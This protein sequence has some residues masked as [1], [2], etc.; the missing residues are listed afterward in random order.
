MN[1][2]FYFGHMTGKHI[3]ITNLER[4]NPGIGGTE[5]QFMLLAYFLSKEK[6]DWQIYCLI[7]ND[8]FTCEELNIVN[9]GNNNLLPVINNLKIDILILPKTRFQDL[10]KI[11][12]PQHLKLIT[13]C[14]N[15]LDSINLRL[16][17]KHKQIKANVFVGKQFYDLYSDCNII[18]KTMYIYNIIT[19]PCEQNIERQINSKI[20]VYIGAL[21]KAKG[22][23]ELAKIWKDILK[24]VPDAKLYVIGN[25][26]LYD[27]DNELGPLG[28]ADKDFEEEFLPY[29][30]NENG[31]LPNVKF[32]G[33]LGD[34]KYDIFSK[35]SVGVANPSGRTETFC[36]TVPE[37]NCATLPV[38][39][40]NKYSFPDVII[41]GQTG[42]LGKNNNEIKK[43]I[44]KLL[45]N[46]ELNKRLGLNA[47][48][49]IEKF[50]P[51]KM[52]VQWIELLEK[53]QN[54]TFAPIYCPPSPPFNNCYKWV[55]I[56]NRFLRFNCKLS[57]L[58]P[59]ISYQ[60]LIKKIAGVMN[61]Q[62]HVNKL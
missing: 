24:E 38:T 18:K 37:M 7:E 62:K 32:L 6:T 59:I 27:R 13:K 48:K 40:I 3:D 30:S 41:N 22:F 17:E 52:V 56:I 8:M 57:F 28:V 55:I 33:L 21:I 42:L 1:I 53:V 9:I 23:L 47:K 46:E 34:E 35:A 15:Y 5:Y 39:T 61:S 10:P 43:Y 36:C 51:Q 19:D 49:F 31:L 12:F 26:K 58:P 20:V 11:D 2:G 29:I 14:D 16:I 60:G 25:G 44:I 45:C 54:E 4:G 50:S